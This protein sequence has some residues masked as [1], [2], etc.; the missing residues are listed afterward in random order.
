[1]P[2]KPQLSRPWRVDLACASSPRSGSAARHRN[3]SSDSS[4]VSA[5]PTSFGSW[6]ATKNIPS[7][8]PQSNGFGAPT[9]PENIWKYGNGL[10]SLCRGSA[11]ASQ[12]LTGVEQNARQLRAN[13]PHGSQ[14]RSRGDKHPQFPMPCIQRAANEF[15]VD[16]QSLQPLVFFGG[17][18]SPRSTRRLIPSP[19]FLA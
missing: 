5:P 9:P 11:L 13:T 19:V 3:G 4:P 12:R 16:L 6:A 14:S 10:P 15:F 1:M 7:P 17:H 18:S 2:L 8:I